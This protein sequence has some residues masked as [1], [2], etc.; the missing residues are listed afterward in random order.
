LADP[1]A[2]PRPIVASLASQL[3]VSYPGVLAGYDKLP[4]RWKHTTE[5]QRRYGYRDFT[6]EPAHISL[7]RYPH[8]QVWAGDLRPTALFRVARRRLL[9]D[10]VLLPG[11]NVLTRT[12]AS[13]RERA[14]RR[15]WC[16]D[17]TPYPS[18]LV[19]GWI[20]TRP[21]H[22]VAADNDD[23]QLTVVITVHEPDPDLC[24]RGFKMRRKP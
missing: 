2:V 17:D 4:V 16:S 7:L 1:A 20:G 22:V 6:S 3:D 15:L 21:V 10:R 19:L 12:V 14:T 5:I 11:H 23:D 8:C 9:D 13:V 18:R 24:E